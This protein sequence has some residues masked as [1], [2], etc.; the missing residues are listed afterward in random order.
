MF[1]TWVGRCGLD[2][3][4]KGTRNTLDR[5]DESMEGDLL[6]E[7]AS[8]TDIP[9]MVLFSKEESVLENASVER[10]ILPIHLR[11]GGARGRCRYRHEDHLEG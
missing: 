1:V 2:C 7:N 6:K 10:P 3:G 8:G 4:A 9:M 11:C 5:R